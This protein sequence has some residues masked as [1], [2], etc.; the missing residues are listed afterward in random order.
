MVADNTKILT[1]EQEE[2]LRAPIDEFVGGI[3]QKIDALRA[4]GTDKVLEYQSA[5]EDL[6]RDRIY[7]AEEKA[8]KR[9]EYAKALEKAKA[10][11]AQNKAEVSKLIAQA[12]AYLKEHYDKDYYQAVV[13]SCKEEQALAQEKYQQAVAQLN[14]EHQETLAKLTDQGEIKDEKYVQKNRLFDAK[15]KLAQDIQETK[16]RRHAAFDHK[17]HLIDMLRMSKFTFGE[18]MAQRVENYKY[19]F[20]RRDFLLRN[21]LYIAIIVIFAALCVITP[22]VKGTP[23]LTASN[24][25]NILSQASPRM[26]LALG[27]AGLILLAG[28]DLSIGRMVGMGMTAATIVMHNGPNTGGVFGHVFDFSGLP[29]LVRVFLALVV[30]VVLCTVFT[31]I[32][33]FFTAKFKMHPFISTMATMLVIFGLVTYSTKG[34]SFGAIDSTIPNMIIP[35]IKVLGNFPTIILWAVAAVIVVWFIWNKTTFGKNLYAVGG[36]PE[37]ASVSGIS[38]FWVTVGAFVMAGVLYGFGSWLECIRMMG[39]GSAA[40]GQGWEMDAIAACVV[41]GVSFTG[42]IGK[43]SGCVVGV[44]IFTALTYSLTVL[45]IDANLQFVF[46]GIII[47]VAVM[48]DCL[49]YVQKK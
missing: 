16:D 27:V 6:K 15:M 44:F 30:C 25:L 32:A 14:Q 21:G 33:G 38:V 34:T 19:T 13:T 8:Q 29:V 49:K 18:T 12:E 42:G 36:N 5:L 7:T 20:N 39:S 31:T 28:T 23:L 17:Y 37:A 26:F 22:V 46:S 11:E 10:V 35:R 1:A 3:Q 47:L 9:A 48:L 40:Y 41:G 4:D 24:I 45:G 2:Q 43:I